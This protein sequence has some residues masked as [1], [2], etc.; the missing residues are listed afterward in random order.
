MRSKPKVSALWIGTSSSTCQPIIVMSMDCLALPMASRMARH[1][2][3]TPTF[4]ATL[5]LGV[6]T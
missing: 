5:L 1:D 4:T 2:S 3:S 6:V